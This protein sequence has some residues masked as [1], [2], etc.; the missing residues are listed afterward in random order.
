MSELLKPAGQGL[1]ALRMTRK[2]RAQAALPKTQA[3][4]PKTQAALPKTE[5]A[6]LRASVDA[7]FASRGWQ[8]LPFQRETWRAIAQ[9]QSGLVHAPTGTGKTQ[10]LW[11]GACMH[12]LSLSATCE[13]TAPRQGP[14]LLWLTPMRA[15]ASDT[16]AALRE[17][18]ADTVW[19]SRFD[20]GLRT[21]D[22]SSAERQRQARRWPFALVTTPESLCLMLSRADAF[23]V[24]GGLRFV[25]VDEWHELIGNKRGVLLQLALAWLRHRLAHPLQLWALSASL[26][27]L[28]AA[29]RVLVPDKPCMITSSK[30]KPIRVDCLLP[31]AS[32]RLAWAGHLGLT[33]CEQL[34]RYLD[35]RKNALVFT[36]TRSQAEHWYQAL[37]DARPQWAGRMALHHA[38]LDLSVRRWVEQALKSGDLSLVVCTSSLDLGVDFSPVEA[39]IQI[40]SPK[41]VARLMQRA[42]RSG[43]QPGAAASITIV[44]THALEVIEAAA[45]AQALKAGELESR[46]PPPRPIDVLV[47]FMVTLA[48]GPGFDSQTL[49]TLLRQTASF[50]DLSAQDFEW[51]LQFVSRGGESLRAYPDHHRV[52]MGDDGLWRVLRTD[53]MRRH[54]MNIGTILSDASVQVKLLHG[55]TLGSV[56]ESFIARLRR[57]DCFIF[58]GRLL[59]L[60]RFHEMTAYVR[61]AP[62]TKAAVPRW[63]GGK[64]PLSLEMSEAL[65]RCLHEASTGHYKGPAMR[66]AKQLLELQVSRSALPHARHLLIEHYRSRE[67]YHW[68]FYP[69]QGRQVHMGLAALLGW[70]LAKVRPRS[71]SIAVNDYGF[72]MLCAEPIEQAQWLEPQLWDPASIAEDCMESFNATELAQR[73]FREIARIAGLVQQGFPS[74]QASSRQLQASSSLFWEVFNRY[75]SNH[76]LLDQA[77]REVLEQ[78]LEHKRLALVFRTIN[79]QSICWQRIEKPSPFSFPLMLERLRES[80]SSEKLQERLARMMASLTA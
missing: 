14:S 66:W 57:G 32:S 6:L 62:R 44:P 61:K 35:Q 65:A 29:A 8:A 55:G 51:A 4:S 5:A 52:A 53:L 73:R 72:E 79:Q 9:G 74:K 63:Q 41:G 10:A 75:D 3:A 58:S 49:Y 1:E 45:A 68:F 31:E 43:H 34:A 11:L 60:V 25:M 23:Q 33:M 18:F 12:S 16:L 47:Q 50:C 30:P 54:R 7:Y 59:E 42:G 40:G 76:L 37:L 56:E 78:E 70:R 19:A 22:T 39:V 77:R 71:F 64:M 2:E 48:C 36:N 69:L 67:G 80:L 24:L 38:S 17:P 26:G 46:T 13:S 28:E 21:G 15:L 20:V 27:D